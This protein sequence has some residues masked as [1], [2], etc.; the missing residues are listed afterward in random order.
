MNKLNLFIVSP[1]Q[2]Q[3][4]FTITKERWNDMER[5]AKKT[6]T[7]YKHRLVAILSWITLIF[8]IKIQTSKVEAKE[9]K[10]D[11]PYP[12]IIIELAKSIDMEPVGGEE[13]LYSLRTNNG[14][15]APYVFS[16]AKEIKVGATYIILFW[17][18]KN[19]KK[20]L[21]YALKE[22]RKDSKEYSYT[23][24]DIISPSE[25]F[26]HDYD[27]EF[28]YGMVKYDGI[29]GVTQDLSSFSYLDVPKEHG[30]Q[31]IYPVRLSG[32][33]PI[34]IHQKNFVMVL[35]R[36]KGR[37]LKYVKPTT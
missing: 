35:Y 1:H 4:L 11:L 23:I 13:F 30:P 3:L 10:Y 26:G 20:Y 18:Q 28:S 19:K 15:G 27:N 37:W 24:K 14:Q 21:V 7:I 34:I 5:L 2:K 12:G 29:L 6:N 17:C 16:Q 22:P 31:N 8:L 32:F 9:K 25:L 36:Y 33:L